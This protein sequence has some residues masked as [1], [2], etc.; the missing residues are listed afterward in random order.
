MTRNV[1]APFPAYRYRVYVVFTQSSRFHLLYN[2][3]NEK[4]RL[5]NYIGRSVW[6]TADFAKDIFAQQDL[7][8]TL[9]DEQL[10]VQLA[11][12]LLRFDRNNKYYGA[13]CFYGDGQ[14]EFTRLI[15][16]L[17][18]RDK[19]RI[20]NFAAQGSILDRFL[21]QWYGQFGTLE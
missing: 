15:A 6:K 17:A 5:I 2:E 7:Y 12:D 8:D 19:M 4:E 20:V 1:V 10:A 16:K 13:V 9:I 3:A 21:K 14:S 11:R 18:H